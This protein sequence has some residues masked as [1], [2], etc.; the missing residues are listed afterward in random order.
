MSLT[1]IRWW[2]TLHFRYLKILGETILQHLQPKQRLWSDF[3]CCKTSQHKSRQNFGWCQ[4]R[5]V[6]FQPSWGWRFFPQTNWALRWVNKN[7][8][9]VMTTNQLLTENTENSTKSSQKI[10]SQMASLYIWFSTSLGFCLPVSKQNHSTHHISAAQ[11]LCSWFWGKHVFGTVAWT[12]SLEVR[13]KK[14]GVA[15]NSQ[16]V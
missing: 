16:V 14:A 2:C 12:C 3:I 15:P 8:Q 4:K 11:K 1:S 10:I 9:L 5:L 13:V 6:L 7:Y